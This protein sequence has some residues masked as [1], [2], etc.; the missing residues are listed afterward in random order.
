MVKRV[1]KEPSSTPY[2]DGSRMHL[3]ARTPPP[4]AFFGSKLFAIAPSAIPLL[5]PWPFP[6]AFLERTRWWLVGGR[7]LK[8]IKEE[9]GDP[10]SM[11]ELGL[12][13]QLHREGVPFIDPIKSDVEGD[14]YA[15]RGSQPVS[16]GCQSP[17]ELPCED[18]FWDAFF[19]STPGIV[20]PVTFPN[21]MTTPAETT[22]M[23]YTNQMQGNQEEAKLSMKQELGPKEE[24][25][26]IDGA[27]A[28]QVQDI[29]QAPHVQSTA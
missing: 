15:S 20:D 18:E 16:S 3:Y 25:P 12:I 22:V 14:G 1:K 9:T 26:D 8:T 21:S 13:D 19:R 10:I 27:K 28:E 17:G 29:G 11:D 5:L 23:T 4:V 24:P 6:L 7:Y 2:H